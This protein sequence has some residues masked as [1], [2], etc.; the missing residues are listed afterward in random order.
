M[1]LLHHPFWL[2]LISALLVHFF[3]TF[4]TIIFFLRRVTDKNVIPEM[5]MWVI[6]FIKSDLKWCMHLSRG[7][8]LYWNIGHLS[9]LPTTSYYEK[10]GSSVVSWLGCPWTP[11]RNCVMQIRLP[12]LLFMEKVGN[13]VDSS[14]GRPLPSS[15]ETGDSSAGRVAKWNAYY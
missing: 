12:T 9:G 10:V 13:S 15:M 2:Q 6:L 7:F 1:V 11:R 8:F 14:L 3:P 4:E 5:R